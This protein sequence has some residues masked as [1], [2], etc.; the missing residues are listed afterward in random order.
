MTIREHGLKDALNKALVESLSWKG[1]KKHP[2]SKNSYRS[3]YFC[4]QVGLQLHSAFESRFPERSLERRQII[5]SDVDEKRPG[6]WLLDIVWCEETCA[7]P[8]SKSKYPSKIYGALECESSTKAKEFFTD[9]AKLVHVRSSIKLY[10]AGVNH[11]LE[12]KM[13]DYIRMRAEQAARFLGTT[14]VSSETD[15]WYLAF[16]PSPVGNVNRSLW[17][18]LDK[19]THLNAIQLFALDQRGAFV[20]I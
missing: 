14:G 8:A 7:D 3:A 1:Y 17:D 19:Y 11:K 9:F 2:K 5:F 15:E 10:L 18:E 6:E 16:W 12:G 13:T 20:A 4:Y